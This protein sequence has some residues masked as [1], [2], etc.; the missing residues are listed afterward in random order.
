MAAKPVMAFKV[1]FSSEAYYRTANIILE[2][3]LASPRTITRT[4]FYPKKPS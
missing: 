1:Y 3:I 4:K 2:L